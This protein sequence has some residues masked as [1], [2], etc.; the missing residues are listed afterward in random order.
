MLRDFTERKDT[1]EQLLRL[2]RLYSVLSKVNEA[3]IRIHDQGKL[4]EQVCRIAVEEGLF[5]MA[6]VGITDPETHEVRPAAQWGDIGGY[7]DT[8]RVVADDAPDGK[9]P[10]GRAIYELRNVVCSD[11][12]NDPLMHPWRD[13]AL[14]HG[15]RSSAAFPLRSASIVIGALTVY[16]D[17]PQFFVDEEMYL[18]SALAGDISYAIDSITSEKKRIESE[19]KLIATNNLLK[20]FSQTLV[21]K[22]Y[23]DRLVGLLGA[24]SGCA[25]IGVRVM[26][27]SGNIAYASFSGFS[28]EFMEQENCLSLNQDNCIC[29]RII[30]EIPARRE[31]PFVTTEGSFFCN[32]TDQLFTSEG[33][34]QKDIYREGC[35]RQGFSSVAVIPIRYRERV[36]GAIHLAD[37]QEGK[38]P[39]GRITFIESIAPLIGEALYRFS[40]EEDLTHSRE[41]LRALSEY[42]QTTREEERIR[43]AREIHDELGQILTAASIELAGIGE[44]Y[45]D[46]KAILKKIASASE[47]IDIATEDV[48]RICSE[49]RPRILD[50][51]GLVAA[52]EWQTEEFTKRSGIRCALEMPPDKLSLPDEVSTALFRVFQETLTN[53]ARHAGAREVSVCL[54]IGDAVLLEVRDDGK[55]ITP[56]NVSNSRSFGI[57]GIQERIHALGGTVSITGIRDK[58]TTVVVKVPLI[59]AGGDH[60]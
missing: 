58:G 4:Y 54:K 10:T 50:H 28:P 56:E 39:C 31:L 7:L 17:T 24:W 60:V 41:Q 8:I 11:I 16:S 49:L 19:E 38:V 27:D 47:L 48:Q 36:L 30:A 3:I 29:P 45:G 57:I 5:K 18:L 14:S 22:E 13:K 52:I 44:G 26:D 42:L 46:H 15:F 33:A 34:E 12:A 20:L 2:N 53:A 6:W 55:G 9:G 23:L 21:R 32:N 37:R 1:D 35:L 59:T 43:M 25:N 40:I 51:L